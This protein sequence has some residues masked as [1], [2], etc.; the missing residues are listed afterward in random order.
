MSKKLETIRCTRKTEHPKRKGY[1]S[2]QINGKRY[3]VVDKMIKILEDG[4]KQWDKPF[5]RGPF[6]KNKE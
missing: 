6:Y 3:S 1:P 2:T 5:G 4:C